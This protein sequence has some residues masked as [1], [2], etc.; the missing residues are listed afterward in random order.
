MSYGALHAADL[1]VC[2]VAH[3]QP[4]DERCFLIVRPADVTHG[5]SPEPALHPECLP[6]ASSAPAVAFIAPRPPDHAWLLRHWDRHENDVLLFTDEDS[7]LA[8]LVHHVRGSWDNLLGGEHI[9]DEATADDRTAVDLY[10]GPERNDL[11]DYGYSLYAATISGTGRTRVVPLD[12][13]FPEADACERANRGAVFHPGTHG[14]LPCME[15]DGV[16]TAH[17]LAEGDSGS[18]RRRSVPVP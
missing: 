9:P 8:E 18:K 15:V 16:V 17:L 5:C 10:Y 11:P 13:W 1:R 4:L 6:S 12:F 2:P 14:G 3:G 7:A